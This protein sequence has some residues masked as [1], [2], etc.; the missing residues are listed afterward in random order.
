V[1]LVALGIVAVLATPVVSLVTAFVLGWVLAVSGVVHLVQAIRRRHER[2]FGW[3]LAGA[4]ARTV[5]G[6]LLVL[7]PGTGTVVL[8]SIL[9]T[10]F[11]I[12]GGL[13][14]GQAVR[15]RG[16]EGRGWIV[17]D[18]I[19]TL[20]LGVVVWGSWPE[21]AL[22]VIGLLIGVELILAGTSILVMAFALRSRLAA[23][24]T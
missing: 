19:V 24:R 22:W 7:Y 9:G 3:N 18:G 4:I 12:Q 8:T 6:V 14:L 15:L 17:F 23:A 11:L 21:S 5:A 13:K 16:I 1:V 20:L 10:Y 2:G